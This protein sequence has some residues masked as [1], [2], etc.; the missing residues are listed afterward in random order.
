MQSAVVPEENTSKLKRH[1]FK[2]KYDDHY[3]VI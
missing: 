3:I 2:P 1:A